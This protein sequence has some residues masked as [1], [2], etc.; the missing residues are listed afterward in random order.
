MPRRVKIVF[1]SG[2]KVNQRVATKIRKRRRVPLIKKQL[3]GY[4]TLLRIIF[5]RT[6]SLRGVAIHVEPLPVDGVKAGVDEDVDGVGDILGDVDLLTAPPLPPKTLAASE[7][8]RR[9]AL[10]LVA[11]GPDE[12]EVLPV[13]KTLFPPLL[14]GALFVAVFKEYPENGEDGDFDP[15]KII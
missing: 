8:W 4:F 1:H 7:G 5:T 2:S 14:E 12:V 11:D 9:S 13:S 3:S 10:R 6:S 15:E